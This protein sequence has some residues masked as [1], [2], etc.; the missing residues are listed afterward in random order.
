MQQFQN[1]LDFQIETPSDEELAKRF[2]ARQ[3]TLDI[4]LDY[5]TGVDQRHQAPRAK[6]GHK[7]RNRKS[8]HQK[9]MERINAAVL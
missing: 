4:T 8:K 1:G 2:A 5:L 7:T 9:K 3:Q 6:K